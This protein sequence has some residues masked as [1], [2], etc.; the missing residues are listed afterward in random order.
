MHLP[1][2]TVRMDSVEYRVRVD[3]DGPA[4]MECFTFEVSVNGTN[5]IRPVKHHFHTPKVA[6][7]RGKT[8]AT[9]YHIQAGNRQPTEKITPLSNKQRKKMKFKAACQKHE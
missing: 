6:L 9:R 2:D 8:W 7:S 3:I 4:D 5:L 1:Q